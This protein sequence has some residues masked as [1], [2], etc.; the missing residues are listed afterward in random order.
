MSP[1]IRKCV[2]LIRRGT[3]EADIQA[4]HGVREVMVSLLAVHM[5]TVDLPRGTSLTRQ[6]YH[7]LLGLLGD[8]TMKL[9]SVYRSFRDGTFVADLKKFYADEIEVLHVCT[10]GVA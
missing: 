8:H 1:C 5:Q 4:N 2:V 9:Q 3:A 10:F 7:G 6:Q